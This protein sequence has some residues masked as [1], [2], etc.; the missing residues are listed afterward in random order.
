MDTRSVTKETG[1]ARRPGILGSLRHRIGQGELGPLPIVVGMAAIWIYFQLQD[2]NFLSSRNLTFLLLQMTVTGTV[3][4]GI[5]LVLLLGEIDLSAGSVTGLSAA[6]LG[7]LLVQ[8]HQPLWLAVVVMLVVAALIGAAQ[9]SIAAFVG[10]PAFVVT[11]AGMLGWLGMQLWVLGPNGSINVSDPSLTLLF[12]T[13]VP[14]ILGWA[15][16]ITLVA[17]YA[18][19]RL[20]AN[21]QRRRLRLSTT[22]WTK[23]LVRPSL[24]AVLVLVSVGVLNQWRGV[25]LA[26]L[27]L[28][29]MVA[30]IDLL[31]T[32]TSFGQHVFAVGGNPEAARRAGINLAAV[33]V[34][35]FAMC[36]LMAGVAGLMTVSRSFAASTQ[37]GGG[38]LLL[39]AIAAAVIGGTSLFGGRGS[40]W[41]APLGALVMASLANG[42]D[43]TGES[44]AIK[45]VVEM[46][47]LLVAVT[48][49]ALARRGRATAGR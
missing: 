40:V 17:A 20:N 28:L 31:L 6:I 4:T 29:L 49:D 37:T 33:R 30:A 1:G 13:Y 23:L 3:A 9:G 14:P 12:T 27:I 44:A 42:L 41:S 24:V 38:T 21:R 25:P 2:S 5:V 35:I 11:L 10:V 7:V 26:V 15:G 48:V 16:G 32:R 36:A 46:I 43:L 47:V 45:Y 34:T 22:P 18:G 8:E 19:V 39:E